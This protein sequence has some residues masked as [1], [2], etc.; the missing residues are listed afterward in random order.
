MEYWNNARLDF[1]FRTVADFGFPQK[2]PLS[3]LAKGYPNYSTFHPSF[4]NAFR[5]TKFRDPGSNQTVP[6]RQMA[7]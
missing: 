1:R 3:I 6:L 4:E 2:T 5:D 7:F